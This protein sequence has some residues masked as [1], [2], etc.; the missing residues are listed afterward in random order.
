MEA[1]VVEERIVYAASQVP[2]EL[3]LPSPA[4]AVLAPAAQEQ[5]KEQDVLLVEEAVE[6]PAW[7]FTCLNVDL[8]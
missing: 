8:V 3:V 7:L 5:L 1:A 2:S 4:A 6:M